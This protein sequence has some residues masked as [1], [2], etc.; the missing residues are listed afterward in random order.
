MVREPLPARSTGLS[1]A[2]VTVPL[3]Y[4]L[5]LLNPLLDRAFGRQSAD[6]GVSRRQ[7]DGYG[8][9]RFVGSEIIG[10][11]VLKHYVGSIMSS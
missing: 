6:T 11:I 7:R 2:M 10:Q 8:A 5:M 9:R 1:A 4:T 3:L